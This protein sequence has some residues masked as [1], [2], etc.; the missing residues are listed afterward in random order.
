MWGMGGVPSNYLMPNQQEVGDNDHDCEDPHLR[1]TQTLKGYH[2]QTSER[3]IGRVTDFMMDDKSWA[4]RRLVVETGHWFSGKEIAISPKQI[5]RVSY[6]ESK[7]FVKVTKKAILET[8]ECHV[9]RP[10]DAAYQDTRNCD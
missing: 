7:V 8:P 3:A 4:I 6:E 9:V 2:I 1:S 10:L 5:D